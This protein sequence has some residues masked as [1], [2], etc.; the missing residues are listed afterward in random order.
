MMHWLEYVELS[1][2]RASSL[3]AQNNAVK[4]IRISV[5]AITV[6]SVFAAIQLF[7]C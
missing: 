6:S 3:T 1:E 7:L 4:S 5:G 2:A